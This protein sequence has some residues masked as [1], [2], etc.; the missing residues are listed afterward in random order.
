MVAGPFN[1]TSPHL[2]AV[3]TRSSKASL[4]A[5][6]AVDPRT[7]PIAAATSRC[8]KARMC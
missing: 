7:V 8:G 4:A 1:D 3:S 6:K 5:V 2:A